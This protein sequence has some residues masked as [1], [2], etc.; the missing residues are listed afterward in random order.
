[1]FDIFHSEPLAVRLEYHEAPNQGAWWGIATK[2]YDVTQ[3]SQL[4][5]WIY[6]RDP[7]QVFQLRLKDTRF[8]EKGVDITIEQTEKWTQSCTKLDEFSPGVLLDRLESIN[9]SFDARTGNATVWVD[10]FEFIRP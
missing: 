4:C 2:T 8:I 9:L 1:V 3:F 5:F 6:A 10:D 7:F